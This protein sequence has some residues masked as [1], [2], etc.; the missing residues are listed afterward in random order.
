MFTKTM[1]PKLTVNQ[2]TQCIKLYNAGYH[3]AEI[4]TCVGLE[5]SDKV[6]LIQLKKHLKGMK[7]V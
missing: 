3:F 7:N 2:I 4:I 5:D 1:A 6:Q